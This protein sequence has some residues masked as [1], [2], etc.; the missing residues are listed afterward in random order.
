MRA[1]IAFYRLKI[2]RDRNGLSIVA[3]SI[4]VITK[5]VRNKE[6]NKYLFVFSQWSSVLHMEDSK[7]LE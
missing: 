4:Q 5:Q 3:P 2:R 1:G 7:I 6:K